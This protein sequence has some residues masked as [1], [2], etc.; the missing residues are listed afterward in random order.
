MT[1]GVLL[2]A[3]GA[4]RDID[5]IP[6]YYAH[7]RHGRPLSAAVQQEL[8]DRYRAIGGHSPLPELTAALA[9]RLEEDLNRDE[10]G[11]WR[12][13][14]GFRHAPPFVGEVVAEMAR[15]GLQEGVALALAP[16]YSA[17]ST[18]LY[19]AAAEAGLEAL[20]R[21][22]VLRYIRDWHLQPGLIDLLAERVAAVRAQVPPAIRQRMPV[23]FT[24][25]SLPVRIRDVG[26]PYPEELAETAEAVARRLRL[27]YWDTAWQ[28]AGRTA[29]PWLG[30]DILDKMRELAAAGVPGLIVCPAGFT[31]D[32]LE[33]LY[34]LDIQAR[35]LAQELGLWFGRTAS[36]NA[37]PA[38]SRVLAA[39]VREEERRHA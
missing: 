14:Y 33:V 18:D 24:A 2:M 13:F 10:P 5:D 9:A 21:P 27:T 31:Q 28:S 4:A 11:T 1:K 34:D 7:I 3:H 29:E 16:H 8:I 25:H 15:A 39:L 22:L 6:R 38:F 17:F 32:H 19:I 35:E 30:P 23:V 37:D 12:V 36:L 20:G 26:D